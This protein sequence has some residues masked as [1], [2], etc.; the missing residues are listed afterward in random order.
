METPRRCIVCLEGDAGTTLVH[1][2]LCKGALGDCHLKCLHEWI[3]HSGATACGVCR[4]SYAKRYAPPGVSPTA[5]VPGSAFT[6]PKMVSLVARFYWSIV[7]TIFIAWVVQ[8]KQN[9][10]V[11]ACVSVATLSSSVVWLL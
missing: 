8:T 1:A 4:G 6:L 3:R 2:C 10:F 5:G 9:L 11:V 7:A